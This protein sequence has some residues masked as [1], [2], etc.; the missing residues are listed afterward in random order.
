MKQGQDSHVMG[1]CMEETHLGFHGME[2]TPTCSNRGKECNIF[3]L[4]KPCLIEIYPKIF[5]EGAAVVKC[6]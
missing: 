6:M 3:Y 5:F 1:H 2:L 4:L